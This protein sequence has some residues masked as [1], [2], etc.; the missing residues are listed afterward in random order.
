MTQDT[1]LMAPQI[2]FQLSLLGGGSS[3]GSASCGTSSGSGLSA[4]I[5]LVVCSSGA[6]A[7]RLPE[8]RGDLYT[9]GKEPQYT[10]PT[11]AL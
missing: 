1:P 2:R 5:S 6:V 7:L 4:Q 10:R 9:H 3:E 11:R 8:T